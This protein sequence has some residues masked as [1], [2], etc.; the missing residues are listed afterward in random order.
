[1]PYFRCVEAGLEGGPFPLGRIKR[2]AAWCRS[3]LGGNDV[4]IS[5]LRAAAGAVLAVAVLMWAPV[6]AH[7][8]YVCWTSD[9][10]RYC[11]DPG[12]RQVPE[13]PSP[14]PVEL[15][16]TPPPPA[17]SA[18]QPA[19]VQPPAAPVQPAPVQPAPAPVPVREVSVPARPVPAPV[20]VPPQPNAG[21]PT[22]VEAT[23]LVPVAAEADPVVTASA[24]AAPPAN[25]P[26]AA[27]SPASA[28]PSL[29]AAPSLSAPEAASVATEQASS[30]ASFSSLWLV[31]GV[32]GLT[33]LAVAWAV[34]RRRKTA[35]AL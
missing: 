15:P 14:A 12:D 33:A 16:Y 18:E 11:Y 3:L 29:T 34:Y 4:G 21:V 7:A 26:A 6:P 27:V 25:A 10:T 17:P 32:V 9:G 23:A 19:V 22:S 30:T 8:D 28:K 31:I 24:E 35:S 1:M 5:P 2:T 13:E 20:Y